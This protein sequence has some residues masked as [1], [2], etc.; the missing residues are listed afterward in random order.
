MEYWELAEG[1]LLILTSCSIF[2]QV[3]CDTCGTD[4]FGEIG[5]QN[6]YEELNFDDD[7]KSQWDRTYKLYKGI[8]HFR[9]FH[10][11]PWYENDWRV[12]VLN[13]YPLLGNTLLF[14]KNYDK[15]P[16]EIHRKLEFLGQYFTNDRVV[17]AQLSWDKVSDLLYLYMNTW[18]SFNK[19]I[20]SRQVSIKDKR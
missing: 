3:C 4:P 18:K 10:Q 7:T 12:V 1:I 17:F 15:C 6:V 14:A 5:R 2:E 20:E 19:R 8:K 16:E 13:T 9:E 11:T